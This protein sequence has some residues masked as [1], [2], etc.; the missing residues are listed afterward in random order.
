VHLLS[1][2]SLL[3]A[4]SPCNAS[5]AQERKRRDSAMRPEW[6]YARDMR[7]CNR[8]SNPI[9]GWTPLDQETLQTKARP[10][11]R[12]DRSSIEASTM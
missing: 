4:P 8:T 12:R 6:S 2:R 9:N 1:P 7:I 10:F 5:S 11:N 3:N